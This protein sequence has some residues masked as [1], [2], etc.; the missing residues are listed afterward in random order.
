MYIHR[1]YRY[2]QI[3]C[4]MCTERIF[5]RKGAF[6]IK[7][8]NIRSSFFNMLSV[9]MLQ[10]WYH[11]VSQNCREDIQ[12]TLQVH[13]QGDQKMRML[14]FFFFIIIFFCMDTKNS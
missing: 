4:Y 6:S 5:F 3:S 12:L 10:K 9:Y 7:R 11:V 14:R 13:I 1:K 8:N 2:T